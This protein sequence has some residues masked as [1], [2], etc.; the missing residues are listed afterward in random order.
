MKARA[1]VGFVTGTLLVLSSFAHAFAGWAA[2][3]PAL[4]EAD[5][6]ADV[7]AAVRIGWHFGSVAMLC[8]GVMTLWLAFKVWHDRS[9]STEAIQV[10]AT[11]YCLF[12]LAAFVAR[13]YKP[14]FLLFVLTGLLLGVFGFWRSGETRQS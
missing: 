12:G 7:I 2:L 11:A 3:E 13:D 14:H 1:L 10:V 6:P 9:V 4:A 8:F 5:V